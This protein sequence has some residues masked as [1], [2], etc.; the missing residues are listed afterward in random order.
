[1]AQTTYT[2]IL[3]RWHEMA[4]EERDVVMDGEAPPE[5]YRV[6]LQAGTFDAYHLE[7]GGPD[8]VFE[9]LNIAHP[10]DYKFRSLSV[11]DLIAADGKVVIVARAGFRDASELDHAIP[12]R[13]REPI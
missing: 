8:E 9:I 3:P 12:S 11:G 5:A 4:G 6:I 10:A 13:A 7:A 1:M 2:V